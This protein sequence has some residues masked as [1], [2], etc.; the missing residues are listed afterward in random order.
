MSG[1]KILI[2]KKKVTIYYY[3]KNA[4]S[5]PYLIYNSPFEKIIIFFFR[6]NRY[7]TL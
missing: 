2:V 1:V 3:N 5:K 4:I 6:L 7:L